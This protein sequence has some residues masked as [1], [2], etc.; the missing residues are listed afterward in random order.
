MPIT[1]IERSLSVINEKDYTMPESLKNALEE[2]ALA[3]QLT[4]NQTRKLKIEIDQ[5]IDEI[6]REFELA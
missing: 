2:I 3:N 1:N 5:K 6:V 4:E